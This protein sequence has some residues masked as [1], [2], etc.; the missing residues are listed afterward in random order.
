MSNI[1]PKNLG[2]LYPQKPWNCTPQETWVL[3]ITTPRVIKNLAVVLSYKI[4][5]LS[6]FCTEDYLTNIIPAKFGSNWP[7]EDQNVKC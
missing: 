1:Y 5:I 3:Y 4:S 7:R 2:T 6:K